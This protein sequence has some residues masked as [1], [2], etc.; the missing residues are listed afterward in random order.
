MICPSGE[1]EFGLGGVLRCDRLAGLPDFCR[2]HGKRERRGTVRRN[3][4]VVEHLVLRDAPMGGDD[5]VGSIERRLDAGEARGE[6]RLKREVFVAGA[7]R[8]GLDAGG[9]GV[10][11]RADRPASNG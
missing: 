11:P 6:L 4:H 5:A 2:R 9:A 7:G 10:K 8:I 1:G 3:G